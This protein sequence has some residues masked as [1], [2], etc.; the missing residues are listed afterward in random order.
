MEQTPPRLTATDERP[1]TLLRMQE[2]RRWLGFS[3]GTRS[4]K[5]TRREK[6]VRLENPQNPAPSIRS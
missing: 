4:E 5:K 2:A 1:S 6:A 3:A